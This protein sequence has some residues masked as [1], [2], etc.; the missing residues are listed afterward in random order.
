MIYGVSGVWEVMMV[1]ITIL[2]EPGFPYYGLG[3][4]LGFHAWCL[5]VSR[6]RVLNGNVAGCN[7]IDTCSHRFVVDRF[8]WF[9]AVPILWRFPETLLGCPIFS[10]DMLFSY[11]TLV[12]PRDMP[13]YHFVFVL[14]WSPELENWLGSIDSR[15]CWLDDTDC[16]DCNG[17]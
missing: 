13:S 3:L 2:S 11:L 14:Q 16:K 6:M 15:G 9:G 10:K 1:I 12:C 17:R 7:L 5:N 4:G 8:R